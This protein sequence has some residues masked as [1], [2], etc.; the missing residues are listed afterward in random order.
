M[1]QEVVDMTVIMMDKV[2]T[3]S[4]LIVVSLLLFIFFSCKKNESK[5]INSINETVQI[6]VELPRKVA[7]LLNYVDSDFNVKQ[8]VFENNFDRKKTISKK[9]LKPSN[10][11]IFSYIGL[12]FRE[13]K[14]V[15]YENNFFVEKKTKI[16]K[17][18][19]DEN[20]AG[21]YQLNKTKGQ[22]FF[23]ELYNSYKEKKDSIA[24]LN[25]YKSN[26][27]KIKGTTFKTINE[28]F[29]LEKNNNKLYYN[30]LVDSIIKKEQRVLCISYRELLKYYY[31]E[32]KDSKI[33]NNEFY[34]KISFQNILEKPNDKI[35]L[36]LINK[37]KSTNFYKKNK[38]RID[39]KLYSKLPSSEV[40]KNL[41]LQN[42]AGEK[43]NFIDITKAE[44][45]KYYLLDFWATWCGP[46][47]HNIKIMHKM[48]L[49]QEVD[50]VYISLDKQSDQKK[51][52]MKST[53]LNISNS[54]LFI[55][56][57]ENKKQLT[58][59]NLNQLPRYILI[60]KDFNI[61]NFNMTTPQEDDFLKNLKSYI[62]E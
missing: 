60:D 15:S 52:K 58:K 5:K 4:K 44:T 59:I 34:A 53:E 56:N 38:Q 30:Q 33:Y 22:L 41:L 48:K 61:L 49:P 28:L 50:V 18:K 46:C 3:M 17:L 24:V 51:W 57:E 54:Y 37:I 62:K 40:L 42:K 47:I 21:L 8:I 27:S 11:F 1:G 35:S 2:K 14:L 19:Y 45:A 26:L 16:L 29:F 12:L 23:T 55:E 32:Q 20:N 7:I 9:I 31:L 25:N 39:S 43:L 36:D 13:G 6:D 10:E